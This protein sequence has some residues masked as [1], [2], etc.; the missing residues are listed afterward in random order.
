MKPKTTDVFYVFTKYPEKFF[1]CLKEN[2]NK[3]HID[4]SATNQIL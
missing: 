2:F 4:I 3:F 1:I